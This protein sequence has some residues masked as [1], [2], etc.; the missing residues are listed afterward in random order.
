MERL[1]PEV[2][3]IARLREWSVVDAARVVGAWRRSGVSRA[4]FCRRYGIAAHRLYYW[5]S[6]GEKRRG[7]P[8]RAKAV[9]FHPVQVVPEQAKQDTPSIEIQVL[10][11]PRGFPADEL[12]AVLSAIGGRI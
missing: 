2:H 11:V 3:R 1:D 4:E 7:V 12:R 5:I 6:A 8:A 10:R 9:K